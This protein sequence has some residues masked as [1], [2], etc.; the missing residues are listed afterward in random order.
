MSKKNKTSNTHDFG[1]IVELKQEE[2]DQVFFHQV[3][4]RNV[5]NV[6]VLRRQAELLS[7]NDLFAEALE[8]DQRLAEILPNDPI[9]HY[10]LACSL[11]LN[12]QIAGALAA[13]HAAVEL[14]Y[15]DFARI[16]SDTDLEPLRDHP[17]YFEI[18]DKYGDIDL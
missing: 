11:C 7:Q 8:L 16:E 18:M 1:A 2:F 10:N 12:G 14:G 9:V 6:D 4:R 13:L 3:L 5:N 17:G 15:S